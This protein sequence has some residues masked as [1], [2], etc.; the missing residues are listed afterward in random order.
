MFD[1]SQ[2]KYFLKCYL[3]KQ[4]H[5]KPCIIIQITLASRSQWPWRMEEILTCTVDSVITYMQVLTPKLKAR[6]PVG[7]FW[8]KCLFSVCNSVVTS[9]HGVWRIAESVLPCEHHR[10][11]SRS[12]D[13]YGAPN[14]WL[15]TRV[16]P[17]LS[18]QVL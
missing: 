6:C 16:T 1:G 17:N 8:D 12:T 11:T 4:R 3:Y 18:T 7:T 5:V 15:G 9:K 2:W 10:L 13:R 14:I